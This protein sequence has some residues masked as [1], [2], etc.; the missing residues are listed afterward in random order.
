MDLFQIRRM[1][2]E[3]SGRYDLV[4]DDS[5]GT[6]DM[7]IN[8]AS[9]ALDRKTF[10]QKSPAVHWAAVAIDD[11]QV[12]IPYCRAIK[13]VWMSYVAPADDVAR[14]QLEKRDLQWIIANYLSAETVS[15]G[16]PL[17]WAPTLTRRIPEGV[18]ISAFSTYMTYMDPMTDVAQDYNALV[19]VAPTS[20]A[21][22]IGV[23][24][25]YYSKELTLRTDENY[26]TVNHPTVL[27]RAVML[28]LETFNQ[29]R[30]KIR[31]WREDLAVDAVEIDK[32]LVEE[33]ITEIDQIN[34]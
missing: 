27:L 11:F 12:S 4:D 31:G 29:N 7:L 33:E 5:S 16:T 25:L 1:F 23:R 34:D 30:S 15:S 17:Y 13:E 6:L 8:Q 3:M 28:E 10:H 19:F 21:A 9:R 14:Y 22:L 18:D 26:W 20:A 32:D 24:G 2:R